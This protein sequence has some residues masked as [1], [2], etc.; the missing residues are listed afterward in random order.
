[1][2][3]YLEFPQ[4][5]DEQFEPDLCATCNGSGEG[6]YD[7]STCSAC[8]GSGVEPVQRDDSDDEPPD[9]DDQYY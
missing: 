4:E 9:Y 5:Q 2:C 3:A 6:M 7:G 8:K 1:M